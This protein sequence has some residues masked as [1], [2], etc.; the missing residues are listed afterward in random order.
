MQKL[1][2]GQ[3]C[4]LSRFTD[5]RADGRTLGRSRDPAGAR[6]AVGGFRAQAEALSLAIATTRI[7]L[8]QIERLLFYER[9]R[10]AAAATSN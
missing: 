8:D 5:S 9:L 10:C 2:R 6:A 7:F 4:L 3:G 1:G